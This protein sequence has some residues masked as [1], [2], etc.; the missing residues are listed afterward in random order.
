MF[1]LSIQWLF[2]LA[3]SALDNL[4]S[5]VGRIAPPTY[6]HDLVVG[7]AKYVVI[8]NYYIPLD[9]LVAVSLSCLAFIIF[10]MIISTILQIL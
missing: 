3:Y 10:I 8:A 5:L 7:I 2:N 1:N 9:T 6:I 4:F